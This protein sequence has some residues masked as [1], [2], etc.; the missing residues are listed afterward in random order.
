MILVL[1]QLMKKNNSYDYIAKIAAQN[2]QDKYSEHMSTAA[3]SYVASNLRD[4]FEK[5]VGKNA[6]E[7]YSSLLT[8]I[9]ATESIMRFIDS[10]DKAPD[11]MDEGVLVNY[12]DQS[13]KKAY[14]VYIARRCS[15]SFD[16]ASLNDLRLSAIMTL[17]A[18]KKAYSINILS[19]KYDDKLEKINTVLK[20]LYLASDGAEC[21]GYDY[22][23][24]KQKELLDS[25]NNLIVSEITKTDNTEATSVNS[26]SSKNDNQVS[27]N[28]NKSNNSPH[29]Y[30]NKEY[31][32]SVELPEEWVKYGSVGE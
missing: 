26:H 10:T 4:E 23:P 32:W 6:F 12:M 5:N 25:F 31:G 3:L 17:I 13:A 30:V 7:K 24:K 16:S 18:S 14:N 2:I 27:M 22:Y 29:T 11:I 20:K 15:D 1:P 28:D 21:E 19:G 9:D 8:A